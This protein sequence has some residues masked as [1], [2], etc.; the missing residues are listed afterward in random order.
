MCFSIRVLL[1]EADIA[2]ELAEILCKL[3]ELIIEVLSQLLVADLL[4]TTIDD[5]F[6]KICFPTL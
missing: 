5:K 1:L 4:S 3:T 2:V 6:P